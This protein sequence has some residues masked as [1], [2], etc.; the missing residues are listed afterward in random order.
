MITEWSVSNFKS[1]KEEM[2]FP[3][4]SLCVFAGSNSSGKSSIIQSML[5]IAQ[6]AMTDNSTNSVLLNG[7]LA[8]LGTCEDIA[9]RRNFDNVTQINFLLKYFFDEA[10]LASILE[11]AKNQDCMPD[12][13]EAFP[14][15]SQYRIGFSAWNQFRRQRLKAVS[16]DTGNASYDFDR[17]YLVSFLFGGIHYGKDMAGITLSTARD[18]STY[19]TRS[20]RLQKWLGEHTANMPDLEWLKN[21]VDMY[22]R[23]KAHA[24]EWYTEKIDLWSEKLPQN[25]SIAGVSFK[26]FFAEKIWYEYDYRDYYIRHLLNAMQIDHVDFWDVKPSTEIMLSPGTPELP[27]KAQ[28]LICQAINT[29][30]AAGRGDQKGKKLIAELCQEL[31]RKFTLNLFLS[32]LNEIYEAAEKRSASGQILEKRLKEK[33]EQI[34]SDLSKAIMEDFAP[35]YLCEAVDVRPEIVAANQKLKEHFLT[36]FRYVGP[37]RQEPRPTSNSTQAINPLGLTSVGVSGEFTA[38]ILNNHAMNLVEY[39]PTQYFSHYEG[40]PK[41][42]SKP[43]SGAVIE[44]LEYMGVAQN[45]T[46][47]SRG[48][49]GIQIQVAPH[50]A[51]DLFDLTGVGVGVSQVLPIIVS[52]LIAEP[53]SL[54][55]YEQPEL[56]LHPRVQSRLADFFV[57]LRLLR[58]QCLIETHSEY[59]INR[60]RYHVARSENEELCKDISLFFF[61]TDN[62]ATKVRKVE[63]DKYGYIGDWPKGFFDEGEE[64]ASSILKAAVKKRKMDGR[65]DG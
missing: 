26:N 55:I 39:V 12:E 40:E 34:S 61:E 52:A 10:S 38:N 6:T 62:G 57:S 22:Q 30:A 7:P 1:I 11:A 3:L 32:R 36:K 48:N 51:Q 5:L 27:I 63:M 28:N 44:W 58:K 33:F 17:P 18:K 35:D 50:N 19:M 43:L 46:T 24:D 13:E 59:I 29:V 23:V 47:N 14:L 15:I 42:E 25:A 65:K 8:R 41:I 45:M 49:L 54:L 53:D 56:H 16:K 60:L 20:K 9:H 21:R 4:T 31:E 2:K 37:L 64:L